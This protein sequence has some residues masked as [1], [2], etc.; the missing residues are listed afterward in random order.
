MDRLFGDGGGGGQRLSAPAVGAAVVATALFGAAELLP[1]MSVEQMVTSVN[2]PGTVLETREVSLDLVG[3]GV[4]VAYYVGLVLLL[5]VVGLVQ[6]SRPHARRALTAAGFGL[7]AAML[8]L[9]LGIVRRAADGGEVGLFSLVSPTVGAAPYV[10]IAGVLMVIAALVVSGWRP[11]VPG[12]RSARD[13]DPA[14]DDDDGG[15]PGPIDLTVTP[16]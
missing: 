10:A 15:E 14:D 6:A 7:S 13:D 2:Q 16:A 4:A 3:T 12:R 8:V 11:A 9:L 1:W 5:S